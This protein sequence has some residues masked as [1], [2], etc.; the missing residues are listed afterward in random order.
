MALSADTKRPLKSGLPF[1]TFNS[2]LCRL[3]ENYRVSFL[4]VI[5]HAVEV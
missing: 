1:T 3:L 5:R 4:G 2:Y